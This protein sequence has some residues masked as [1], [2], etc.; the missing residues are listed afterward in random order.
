VCEMIRIRIRPI[1][2]PTRLTTRPID[3]Y[4]SFAAVQWKGFV[5]VDEHL[6]V[7]LKLFLLRIML[8]HNM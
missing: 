3:R 7:Y 1:I 6:V 8:N 5:L 2:W 4:C